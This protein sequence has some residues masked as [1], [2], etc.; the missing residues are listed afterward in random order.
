MA[1]FK[2]TDP[3]TFLINKNKKNNVVV[4]CMLLSLKKLNNS[5]NQK[6]LEYKDDF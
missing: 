6:T 1:E 2:G 4:C 5:E 3:F